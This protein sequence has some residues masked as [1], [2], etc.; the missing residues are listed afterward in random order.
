M[1]YLLTLF[2]FAPI[3]R[4]DCP[5]RVTIRNIGQGSNRSISHQ[6]RTG[7]THLDPQRVPSTH[8]VAAE[9]PLG[10]AWDTPNPPFGPRST[11]QIIGVASTPRDFGCLGHQSSAHQHSVDIAQWKEKVPIELSSRCRLGYLHF[12]QQHWEIH[13]SSHIRRSYAYS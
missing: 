9:L 3:P 1:V 12:Q 8:R 4:H 6:I 10:P 2:S 5:S 13:T 11:G 7:T